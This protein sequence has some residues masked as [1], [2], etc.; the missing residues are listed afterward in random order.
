MWTLLLFAHA[1]IMSDHDS[2]ALTNVTGFPTQQECVVAGNQ[3]KK[4]A[5]MTTKVIKFT[6]M[7]V[8]K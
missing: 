7:K 1:S 3:A 4:M 6:C 8:E 2:M 5:E